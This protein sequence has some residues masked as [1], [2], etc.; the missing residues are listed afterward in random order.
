MVSD[1]D[2]VG[3]IWGKCESLDSF[4]VELEFSCDFEL[5]TF[6]DVDVGYDVL[7]VGTGSYCEVPLI[8]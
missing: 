3:A 1:R 5:D 2:Q 8:W 7:I 6:H 4:C